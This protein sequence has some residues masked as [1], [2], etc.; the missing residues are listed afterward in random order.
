MTKNIFVLALEDWQKSRLETV[1]DAD[2]FI[3]HGLLDFHDLVHAPADFDV[4]LA[5]LRREIDRIAKPDAI[6][7][8]WDYPSSC[9][10]PVLAR[11]YGL[12]YPTLEAVLRCEH[13]Y[14]SRLVQQAAAPEVVPAFEVLDPHDPQVAD[15]MT[16]PFPVWIKPVKS[17]SSMLGF[18]A[19]NVMELRA[20]LQAIAA[21][22]HL[23]GDSFDHC[24][25]HASVPENV[26]AVTGHHALVESLM[27]G[28]QFAVEG[29]VQDGK[30]VPL[31][32]LDMP[33]RSHGK[34]ILGLRYPADL[35]D[36]LCERVLDVCRR[37]LSYAD[38]N[39]G[40]FNVELMWDAENDR[41]WLIEV[42]TRIS[43]SH[44]DLFT[45]VDGRSNHEAAIAVA[46][47]RV[48]EMWQR[49]GRYRQA[50]KLLL[51]K[52]GDAT[53]LSTPSPGR[54]QEISRQLGEALVHLDVK[55]GMQLHE[56]ARQGE[57]SFIVGEAWLGANSED[58][59]LYKYHSL[60]DLLALRFSDG[61]ELSRDLVLQ[62]VPAP[63]LRPRPGPS[64]R[65]PR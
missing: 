19:D 11:E 33:R 8:H 65:L 6:I 40:C 42:N 63:L 36:E 50:A 32:W 38:F 10:T 13:K 14:W 29:Y 24:L 12:R 48:P 37:V 55:P 17:Y 25:Q 53:V 1:K 26:R 4:L 52:I 61:G 47:G 39:D 34:D 7:C 16:L 56:L 30:V 23:M 28:E 49:R 46:L 15:R 60:I 59:L 57:Y 18:R 3:F 20:A 43:Q 5:R 21:R 51:N 2:E 44:S 35:P 64:S 45:K 41:L 62:H 58:E 54:L 27:T 31:G 22:G 9:L